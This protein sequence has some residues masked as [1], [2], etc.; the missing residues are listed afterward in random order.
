MLGHLANGQGSAAAR[1]MEASDS[2]QTIHGLSAATAVRL[3][4]GHMPTT[5]GGTIDRP[6][7]E[8]A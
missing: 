8:A 6:E 1:S 5:W 7:T 2:E 4:A 3:W